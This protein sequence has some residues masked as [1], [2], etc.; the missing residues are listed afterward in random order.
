M[1]EAIAI[2]PKDEKEYALKQCCGRLYRHTWQVNA[3]GYMIRNITESNMELRD[4]TE[5]VLCNGLLAATSLMMDDLDDLQGLLH[6][7][8]PDWDEIKKNQP[9]ERD[10]SD[11]IR[12]AEKRAQDHKD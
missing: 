8:N 1:S 7:P 3:A 6:L 12:E 5:V 11:A 10:L 9:F 2:Q 4:Y